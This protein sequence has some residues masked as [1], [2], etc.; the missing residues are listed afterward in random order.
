[1]AYR[2]L[3]TGGSR[4]IGKAV[5]DELSRRNGYEIIAPSRQELDLDDN[6]SIENFMNDL[7][8]VNALIN[9]AGMNILKPLEDIDD[10]IL[11][12][13]LNVNLIAPLKL[14]RKV[15]TGM[16]EL[17][18]GKIVSFSSIWGIR[19]KEFRTMYSMG[20]FGIRGVTA[21]LARELGPDNILINAI[22][23]GYVLTRMTEE[24]VPEKE[25][26]KICNE[27]PLRRM[28]QPEEI[29]KVAAFLISPDNTYITGQT[30]I[31]D[32][33]FLA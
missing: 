31:V 21:A 20:K 24:N 26:L 9:V 33:G 22:A 5:V 14:I 2:V 32:G 4:G 28:A 25:R 3:V 17:N 13:M 15:A 11:Q 18:G 1:M 7:P 10:E 23:P 30:V 19:S 6:E 29:A 16:K 27:I 8:P 12:S